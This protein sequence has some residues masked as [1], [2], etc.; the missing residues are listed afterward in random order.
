[1]TIGG[2]RL[3]VKNYEIKE[4]RKLKIEEEKDLAGFN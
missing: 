3:F 1:M 4:E 2:K